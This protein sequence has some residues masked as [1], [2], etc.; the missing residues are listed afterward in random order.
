M[1]GGSAASQI[2]PESDN[3]NSPRTMDAIRVWTQE[4]S[5]KHAICKARRNGQSWHPSRLLDL[6]LSSL[7]YDQ[8]CRIV[9]RDLIAHDEPYATLSHRWSVGDIIRLTTENISD[10]S[11]SGVLISSMSRTFQECI[12]F[13]RAMHIRYLWIDSLCIIQEGDDGVDWDC[14]AKTM[15]DV[16]RNSRLNISADWG[17]VEVSNSPLDKR[18]WVLQERLLSPRNVH[19]CRNE[20]FWEC[21]EATLCESFPRQYI[22]ADVLDYN[23]TA[24]LK[25]FN[26][27]E[28]L[29]R[30]NILR[31]MQD[32]AR[33]NP[34]YQ[35]W[36]DILSAYGRCRLTYPSDR[37][38]AVS[39]VA[40]Y[41]KPALDDTYVLGLWLRYLAAEM[42]LCR[43]STELI[44]PGDPEDNTI[45]SCP[46]T[47]TQ[48]SGSKAPS[49]SWA[50]ADGD[51]APGHSLQRGM[52]PEVLCVDY[53]SGP[54]V[55]AQESLRLKDAFTSSAAAEEPMVEIRVTA[56]LKRMRLRRDICGI[57]LVVVP[58]TGS[59][60]TNA[61]EGVGLQAWP[62]TI[63]L[64]EEDDETDSYAMAI[65]D[66]AIYSSE[67]PE[68]EQKV[69]YY[70]PWK[71]TFGCDEG[72]PH[73]ACHQTH[74]LLFQPGHEL[75]H[76]NRSE[77]VVVADGQ[78]Q[79]TLG[80]GLLGVQ[81]EILCVKSSTSSS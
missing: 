31:G 69:F 10:F 60:S 5:E 36:H 79:E 1:K 30:C 12:S 67:F 11:T 59:D 70:V 44:K 27:D 76:R 61:V 73:G 24:N 81:Q 50:A 32:F 45:G 6:G 64:G 2:M 49:F 58:L 62:N 23:N 4:C 42:L 26:G 77:L 25:R 43:T 51:F 28:L 13:V 19:F 41:L 65:L 35:L 7:P 20:V 8:R 21:C 46:G 29:R 55:A 68:L 34:Q 80:L 17:D 18:G 14:E 71:D 74:A 78:G 72:A 75:L 56:T 9:S 54:S 57:Y 22:S 53:R 33:I 16:Y 47:G 48:R 52:L 66:R 37:L 3:T 63:T 15:H 40:R 39:G 38:V